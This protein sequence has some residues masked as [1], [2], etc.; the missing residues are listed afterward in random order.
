MLIFL[1]EGELPWTADR[2]ML[3]N[4][5]QILFMKK[6]LKP[7]DICTCE[8]SKH[9]KVII[10]NRSVHNNIEVCLLSKIQRT[11]QLC[12]HPEKTA[13]NTDREWND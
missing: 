8:S 10:Y 2:D 9:Y 4:F 5:K 13:Q 11:T 6:H 12:L 3:N 7:K 1:L